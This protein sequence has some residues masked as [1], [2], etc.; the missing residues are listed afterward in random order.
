[1]RV[2]AALIALRAYRRV[3]A[4]SRKRRYDSRGRSDAA[5]VTHELAA[6]WRFFELADL[7]TGVPEGIEHLAQRGLVDLGAAFGNEQEVD[8]RVGR[9][10]SAPIATDGDDRDGGWVSERLYAELL[11]RAV[12]IGRTLLGDPCSVFQP[13]GSS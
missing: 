7:E 3:L 9:E 13:D 2:E 12:D 1:M 6:T 4:Q 10:V 5:R 11:E 8:V